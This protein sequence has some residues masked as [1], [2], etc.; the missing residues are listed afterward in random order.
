MPSALA[1][2]YARAL[3]DLAAKPGAPVEASAITGE[4]ESFENALKESVQLKNALESPAVAPAK[5]RAVVAEL[6]RRL[7]LSSLTARFLYVLIDHRRVPLLGEVREA[8]ESVVD[9]RLGIVRV[10]IHSAR[11]LTAGQR[12]QLLEELTRL[13]GKEAR[14]RFQVRDD[15]IGGVVARI[16]STVYDGS[17]RGQ[18]T[19]IKHKLAGAGS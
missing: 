16:G 17:I 11:E 7:P 14:A 8:F 13:T 9:E 2:R 1:F 4:L 15:L 19:A 12:S 18:L 5:K 3:A 10:E 6:A